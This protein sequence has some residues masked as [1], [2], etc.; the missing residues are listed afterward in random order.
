MAKEIER[1]RE[2]E[3]R[4]TERERE[5]AHAANEMNDNGVRCQVY[6]SSSF[7]RSTYHS[8]FVRSFLDSFFPSVRWSCHVS[9]SAQNHRHHL[10]ALD[11]WDWH[12]QHWDADEDVGAKLEHDCSQNQRMKNKV[13]NNT[14]ITKKLSKSNSPW[15]WEL[16]L[17]AI[18]RAAQTQKLRAWIVIFTTVFCVLCP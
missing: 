7:R 3:W 18:K 1:E 10:F 16:L 14:R 8:G 5:L 9:L 11:T 17:K 13:T 15:K 6:I 12:F 2:K 4:M